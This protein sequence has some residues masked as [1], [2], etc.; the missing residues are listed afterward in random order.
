R[1]R[2]SVG[3]SSTATF[4]GL[5]SGSGPS[6][7][8]VTLASCVLEYQITGDDDPDRETRPDG[9]RRGNLQLTLHDLLP[10]LINCVLRAV[11]DGPDQPVL[12]T[13]RQLRADCEQRGQPCGLHQ[14]PK[15]IIDEI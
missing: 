10:G 7:S 5:S 12:V 4:T 3:G 1:S 13:G 2:W 14:I 11:A 6:F 9:E 15:M 8:L